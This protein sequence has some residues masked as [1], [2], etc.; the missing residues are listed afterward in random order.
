VLDCCSDECWSAQSDIQSSGVKYAAVQAFKAYLADLADCLAE[1]VK[2]RGCGWRVLG[3]GVCVG[4]LHSKRTSN[5]QNWKSRQQVV[6]VVVVV[7]VVVVV[8]L[9][10]CWGGGVM[11]HTPDSTGRHGMHSTTQLSTLCARPAAAAV[12]APAV[13]FV[14]EQACRCCWCCCCCCCCCCCHQGPLVEEL[15][16][17]L[18][19][20]RVEAA[21]ALRQQQQVRLQGQIP[22]EPPPWGGRGACSVLAGIGNSCTV[23]GWVATCRSTDTR[24][25]PLRVLACWIHGGGVTGRKGQGQEWGGNARGRAEADLMGRHPIYVHRPGSSFLP[26][27]P[28]TKR[29]L[30]TAPEASRALL[31]AWCMCGH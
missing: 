4:K 2:G 3:G 6:C 21:E 23:Y 12:D 28:D 19:Q 14:A 24:L 18:Q 31:D 29:S 5:D 30:P 15:G 1:K 27:A 17:A 22:P 20:L 7:M 9:C 25:D 10:M 13:T 16:D 26:S 11:Q 8:V